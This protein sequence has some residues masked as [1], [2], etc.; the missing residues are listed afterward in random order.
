MRRRI[1]YV[2]LTWALLA[3]LPGMVRA[4]L[5][6]PIAVPNMGPIMTPTGSMMGTGTATPASNDPMPAL[7]INDTFVSF[8]DSA[9]P[10]SII[11]LR[12]DGAYGDHQPMRATYLFPKG[13]VPGTNGFPLPE[14][15]VDT[16]GLTTYAE[17]S[18]M[19]WLSF[20]IEGSYKWINPDVNSNTSGAGDTV[21]GLKLCTWS[22]TNVIATILLRVYQPSARN[23]TLG[24]GHWSIEPGLLA[25]YRISPTWHL[26]GEF[27]YWMPIGGDDFAGNILRYGIG[28]SYGQRNPSGFWYAPVAEAIGWTILSGKT[29]LASSAD[30]FVIQDARNQ[31]VVN[32]YLGMR[33][34]YGQNLDFYLGYGRTLTG[35]YW[36][37]D[38]YRVEVRLSF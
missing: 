26:E 5:N 18:V 7:G 6:S 33:M 31:T 24:T 10:R 14:T 22:D 17:Y 36:A 8:I 4:Q 29:M 3:G 38:M 16:L 37:R 13:G 23:E 15:N 12:F 2:L 9:V 20:F 30:N 32:A 19:P 27:R 25:A 34:G 1:R 35:E 28:L 11:G 21:Y